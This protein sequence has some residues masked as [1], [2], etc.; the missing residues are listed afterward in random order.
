MRFFEER[1]TDFFDA[2]N[3]KVEAQIVT[4]KESLAILR[5]R[6]VEATKSRNLVIEGAAAPAATATGSEESGVENHSALQEKYYSRVFNVGLKVQKNWPM[7]ADLVSRQ[8]VD[9][10]RIC[11]VSWRQMSSPLKPVVISKR[12]GS[13]SSGSKSKSKK[14]SK[15]CYNMY[16]FLLDK[17]IDHSMS[18]PPNLVLHEFAINTVFLAEE[19]LKELAQKQQHELVDL[20]SSSDMDEDGVGKASHQSVVLTSGAASPVSEEDDDDATGLASKGSDLAAADEEMSDL[21]MDSLEKKR[22]GLMGCLD[23]KTSPD[24]GSGKETTTTPSSDATKTE[25]ESVSSTSIQEA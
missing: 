24:V 23:N 14:R 22:S 20:S 9:C 21:D 18:L 1:L 11:G 16:N 19:I 3:F 15:V 17:L 2:E 5:Q 6:F 8:L 13:N 10:W 12:G 25:E 7:I 4:K